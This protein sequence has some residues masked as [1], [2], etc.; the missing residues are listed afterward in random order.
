MERGGYVYIMSNKL[1]TT[2]YIGVT[3]HLRN[4]VLE[5]KEG[6]ASTFTKRHK[7]TECIYYEG[8]QSIEEAII[9][10]KQLKK[11]KRSWKEDLIKKVNPRLNDLWDSLPDD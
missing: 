10:E 3:S 6:V 9:R 1:R 2:L 5:H 11:W 4:R 8:F 7:C